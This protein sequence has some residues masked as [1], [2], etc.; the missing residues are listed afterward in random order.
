MPGVSQVKG[1]FSVPGS[2]QDAFGYLYPGALLS[3][4]NRRFSLGVHM[5]ITERKAGYSVERE[6][7]IAW[8][9]N[10]DSL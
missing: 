1:R 5:L 2:L 7:A 4:E 8:G 9:W 6:G 3:G 10:L